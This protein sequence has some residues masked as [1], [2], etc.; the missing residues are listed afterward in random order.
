MGSRRQAIQ[1]ALYSQISRHAHNGFLQGL[2]ASRV[3]GCFDNAHRDP[4][5]GVAMTVANRGADTQQTLSR[6]FVIFRITI[7]PNASQ[8][9]K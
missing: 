5:V 2:A 6:F 9:S 8:V 7:F 4:R 3:D 1:P